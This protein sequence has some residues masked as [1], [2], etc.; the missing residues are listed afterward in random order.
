MRYQVT[1][2]LS[3]GHGNNLILR[4]SI[5]VAQWNDLAP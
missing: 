1:S 2:K 4:P 5:D 3:F